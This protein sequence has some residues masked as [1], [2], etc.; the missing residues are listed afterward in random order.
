MKTK[1]ESVPEGTPVIEERIVK[2]NGE[3]LVRKYT[4]GKLLGKGG[5]ARCYEVV[6]IETGKVSAAKVVTKASLVKNRAKQKLMSE[7][8]I[9][10]S[11][12]HPN[13][14]S[15]EQFFED[16]ENVYMLLELC[17][18]QTLNELVR[19][20]RRLTELETKCYMM[21]LIDGLKY[22]HAHRVIHR[23]LKLGNLFLTEK[24]EL[25]IGDFG[26][27][28]KLEFEGERKRTIC[29]TPN[30]IAPEILEGRHGHSYEVDIWSLG[31]ILYT[32]LIGRPPFETQDVK[33]T[34]KRIRMNVY[35]FPDNSSVSD[36]AKSL[37][38]R[39]LCSDPAKR[40]K[41][42]EILSHPFF[43]STRIPSQMPA[44]TLACPPSA[45]YMRQ[46]ISTAAPAI[47]VGQ[48][49]LESTAPYKE[50]FEQKG[51]ERLALLNTERAILAHYDPKSQ[52][53]TARVHHPSGSV[54]PA[55]VLTEHTDNSGSS[56]KQ[57]AA[58]PGKHPTVSDATGGPTKKRDP[59]L[60]S[61]STTVK[62]PDVW[63][64]KWVDYSSKYGLGY[65]LSNGASGV[66]F[67]DSTKVILDPRGYH[68]DYIERRAADR[69]DVV[70][71]YTLTEYPKPLQKKVTLLQHFRSY[72]EAEIPRPSTEGDTRPKRGLETAI[73]VKKWLKTKHAIMF[74][75][76][77]K[78]V[79]V[80]FQDA[81]EII[82]SSESKVVTYV[83]KK[84]EKQSYPLSSALESTNAEMAKRL[85]YTKEILTRMLNQN[86]T[87][88]QKQD[89]RPVTAASPYKSVPAQV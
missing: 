10:R 16:S 87:A 11:L 22:L 41:F 2:A 23:D 68:F 42:D 5:F 76:S 77:N 83:N 56:N 17:V 36:Q 45:T 60:T 50:N 3:T 74:R 31:V 54:H 62:E 47:P 66:F 7:I 37:V 65:L 85:R 8:K 70:T 4:K 1:R 9:H 28:T 53:A 72:L 55:P 79:Q 30:Y 75:L 58:A 80:N 61:A 39:I 44:S 38:Q 25:K 86:G 6:N 48:V 51:K 81:T 20:R 43:T 12:H 67:N 63:I 73:Y 27:A 88:A 64:K 59:V 69:Q 21:Q 24:M 71:A 78:I 15:F 18:N 32:L 29:G 89:L 49:R 13:V 34:Y 35:S 26:L 14:V 46:F 52:A 84:G 19:R 33:T 82:L 57:I 40:P